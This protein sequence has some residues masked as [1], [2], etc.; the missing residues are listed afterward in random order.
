[1]PFLRDRDRE[2]KRVTEID[3]INGILDKYI[4]PERLFLKS[5]FQDDMVE[6]IQRDGTSFIL[7]FSH[8]IAEKEITLYSMVSDRYVEFT[9]RVAPLTGQNYPSFTYRAET[10]ACSLAALKRTEERFFFQTDNPRIT[11]IMVSKV[12]ENEAELKKSISVQVIIKD[13]LDRLEGYDLK[14]A[15][16]I[17]DPDIPP[18]VSLVI[19]RGTS[20]L[21]PDIKD[22]KPF[23]DEHDSFMKASLGPRFRSDIEV[24]LRRFS[25]EFASLAVRVID[26]HSFTSPP[27]P[28][29]YLVLAT[30]GRTMDGADLERMERLSEEISEKIHKGNYREFDTTG[31]VLNL[32]M[33]GA[34]VEVRDDALT[35]QLSLLDGILFNLVFKMRD[36]IRISALV[37]FIYQVEK[38]VYHMGLQ[39]KGSYFGPECRKVIEERLSSLKGP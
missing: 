18:E 16:F 29:C 12:R 33:G 10:T 27:F 4:D 31:T 9:L 25:K 7:A 3:K 36:P 1:M 11:K 38:G 15:Y 23:L 26:F 13:Y 30:E 39:F 22:V 20:L 6:V 21:I 35:R 32:S 37:V 14:K 5:P 8:E 2:L 24:S 19:E 34:L 17:G 28:F